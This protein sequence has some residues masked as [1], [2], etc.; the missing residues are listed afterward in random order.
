MKT[1][2]ILI[3]AFVL[4]SVLALI[5]LAFVSMEIDTEFDDEAGYHWEFHWERP[6]DGRPPERLE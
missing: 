2:R 4:L 3:V 1:R 6:D 5:D